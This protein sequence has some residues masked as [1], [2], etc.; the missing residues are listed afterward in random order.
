M[1]EELRE[2]VARAAYEAAMK[3]RSE[4][5]QINIAPWEWTE[6][7]VREEYRKA[8]EAAVDTFLLSLRDSYGAK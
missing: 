3:M 2:Q 5:G 6:N 1:N 4:Y 7:A 8:G